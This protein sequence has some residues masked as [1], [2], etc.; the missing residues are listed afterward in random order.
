MFKK[1]KFTYPERAKF[2]KL[3]KMK[4]GFELGSLI[5]EPRSLNKVMDG[6]FAVGSQ[7]VS[8]PASDQ[9]PDLVKPSG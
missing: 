3:R 5:P 2:T 9:S 8:P 6:P 1:V 4:T 7:S